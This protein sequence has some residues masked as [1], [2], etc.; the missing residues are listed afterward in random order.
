MQWLEV[1]PRLFPQV[2]NGNK[3]STIRWRERPIVPGYMRYVCAGDPDRT[4]VVWVTRI[5]SMPLRNAAAFVGRQDEWPDQVMLAG[6]REHYPGIELDDE[7]Q[8]IE[9]LTP[10]ETQARPGFPAADDR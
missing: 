2:E 4:V 3:R 1:V 10:A 6:M 7:V 8:V 5:T 9:H